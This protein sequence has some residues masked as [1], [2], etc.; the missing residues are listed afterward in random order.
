MRLT[1]NEHRRR[2]EPRTI[3]WSGSGL[4]NLLRSM[5]RAALYYT[6]KHDCGWRI[7]TGRRLRGCRFDRNLAKGKA[8]CWRAD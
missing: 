4:E 3:T 7:A 1:Y 2:V 8:I 5:L 6:Q